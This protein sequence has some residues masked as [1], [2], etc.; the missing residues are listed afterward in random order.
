MQQDAVR[1]RYQ[2]ARQAFAQG[3]FAQAASICE[4]LLRTVGPRAELLNLRGLALN[5]AGQP[6]AAEAS[7]AA[8]LKQTPNSSGLHLNL[9]LVHWSLA[10]RR[11]ARRHAI[12]AVRL[13]GDEAPVLHQ[14]ARLMRDCGDPAHALR[15]VERCVQR[16]P[17][18]APAWHL[19]GSLLLDLGQRE[20]AAAALQQAVTAD[21]GLARAL[22][23]LAAARGDTLGNAAL[24][25][26]LQA[27]RSGRI[28]SQDAA[29][30]VFCLAD[31]HHRAG[32]ADS[33]QTVPWV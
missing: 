31:L 14:A 12:E 23:D 27:I 21:P 20:P 30:A 26:R 22:R 10:Q 32:R 15:I 7:L 18:F 33:Y 6:E 4:A 16:H 5:A 8:A 28:A 25:E 9:G 19:K 11:Q 17:G 24:V 3:Q 1:N 29:S 2:Q 13:G